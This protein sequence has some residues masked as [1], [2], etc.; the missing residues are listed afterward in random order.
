M[1]YPCSEDLELLDGIVSNEEMSDCQCEFSQDESLNK[2][3]FYEEESFFVKSY[4]G[5]ELEVF[6]SSGHS[7][8]I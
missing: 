3:E 2:P 5:N 8:F 1:P 7:P 4:L 6:E